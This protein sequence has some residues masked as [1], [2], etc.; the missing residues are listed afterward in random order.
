MAQMQALTDDNHQ[1]KMQ[2]QLRNVSAL[3]Q[4]IRDRVIRDR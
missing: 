2:M 4:E 3:E 1:M